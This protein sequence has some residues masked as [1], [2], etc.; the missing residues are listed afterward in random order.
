[1]RNCVINLVASRPILDIEKTMAFDK[2]SPGFSV[3]LNSLLF[4][5]WIELLNPLHETHDILFCL[6]EQDK[7]SVPRNFIPENCKL[8]FI[9]S[10][11]QQN[12]QDYYKNL[13]LLEYSKSILIN[14]NSIGITRADLQRVS[15]L[16]TMPDKTFIVGKATNDH[17]AFFASN[18]Q[19]GSI[20]KKII[21]HQLNYHD[22]LN[23][24]SPADIYLHT[25]GNFLAI[26]NFE[27]VKKLYIELS[28]KESLAYC[29]EIMHE[30]FNDIFIE[31]KEFLNE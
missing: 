8:I 12:L 5:N 14:F 31:Y 29:S 15:D 26:N 3:Y 1:M 23:N 27:D 18:F 10:S 17:V 25:V 13:S 19:P 2:M 24:I 7:D 22:F 4:A 28:K 20:L 21:F 9:N 16:L 30:R 11:S 6:A